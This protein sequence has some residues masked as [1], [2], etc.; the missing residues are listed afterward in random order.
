MLYIQ[1]P[2]FE[3]SKL[4]LDSILECCRSANNGGGA[5]AF[6]SADGINLLVGD[7]AFEHFISSGEFHLIIGMD[8]ITN[9]RTLNAIS[10]YCQ[11][12][13]NLHVQAFLHNTTGSTFHPKFCWFDCGQ[14]G[15]VIAGSGN[16]TQKGMQRNR[17]A[18]DVSQVSTDVIQTVKD[19]WDAWL[20][21]AED[22]LKEIDDVDVIQRAEE[23]AVRMR[24]MR[25]RNRR[26]RTIVNN[27]PDPAVQETS[28]TIPEYIDDEVGAWEFDLTSRVLIAEIPRGQGRWNQAN[29]DAETFRSYF[30]SVPGVAHQVSLILR[31][32]SWDGALGSIRHRPPVSVASHNYRIELHVEGRP[33]YP[34]NGR[35]LGVFA[36]LSA[37]TFLYMLVFPDHREHATLQHLLNE[38][39][40]R[41][42]RL[43]RYQT[44]VA[45]LERLCPSL[46]I[47]NYLS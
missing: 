27:L 42:D 6:V 8:E 21:S 38:Q 16:L 24:A 44:N 5:Y 35:V 15:F 1:D 7:P 29:F 47:L 39:R 43:V 23:N 3:G 41:A 30:E 11:K 9:T 17:E 18:F 33:A 10:N 28:E 22:N 32:V 36:K 19:H 26:H 45:E 40:V 14:Y 12:Y 31:D 2:T 4:L 37:R 13:P 20:Q 46:P 34:A 25:P